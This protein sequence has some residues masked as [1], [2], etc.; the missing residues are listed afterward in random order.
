MFYWC[1][2]FPFQSALFT[3]LC[4]SIE[5]LSTFSHVMLRIRSVGHTEHHSS[6]THL[7]PKVR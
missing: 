6:D 2:A 1:F 4:Q 7:R 5:L 3:T